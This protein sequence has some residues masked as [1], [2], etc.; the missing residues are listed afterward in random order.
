MTWLRL[1]ES[2]RDVIVNVSQIVAVKKE[3]DKSRIT[4]ASGAWIETSVDYREL[5]VTLRFD[6]A[7]AEIKGQ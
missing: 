4:L 5:I 1:N 2:D 3:G 7:M 6:G